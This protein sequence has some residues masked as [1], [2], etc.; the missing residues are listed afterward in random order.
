MKTIVCLT[1]FE[2]DILRYL[3]EGLNGVEIAR[4]MDEAYPDKIYGRLEK[5]RSHWII[6]RKESVGTEQLHVVHPSVKSYLKK[7]GAWGGENVPFWLPSLDLLKQ[8][9]LLNAIG[10]D[11][12]KKGRRYSSGHVWDTNGNQVDQGVGSESVGEDAIKLR[13]LMLETDYADLRGLPDEA[14]DY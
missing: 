6:R 11:G 2:V 10:S 7:I 14:L 12:L 4:E 3:D 8:I 1:P 5:L 13:S 9:M